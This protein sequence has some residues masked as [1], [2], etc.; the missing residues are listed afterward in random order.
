MKGKR[1]G[2][3]SKHSKEKQLVSPPTRSYWY[4][5]KAII[6]SILVA[7]AAIFVAASGQ[8][9]RHSDDESKLKSKSKPDVSS[10]ITTRTGDDSLRANAQD[11]V[12]IAQE[13]PYSVP[14]AQAAAEAFLVEGD[15]LKSSQWS[16]FALRRQAVLAG[17]TPLQAQAT[18]R[19]RLIH[20]VQQLEAHLVFLSRVILQGGASYVL[21][22]EKKCQMNATTVSDGL[23]TN[24]ATTIRR[25]DVAS[26]VA[27]CMLHQ[28]MLSH[29]EQGAN[30]QLAGWNVWHFLA[31]FGSADLLQEAIN[32]YRKE[33][34]LL[35]STVDPWGRDAARI[36]R[37]R[38]F[39]EAAKLLAA[40]DN[41]DMEREW[42]TASTTTTIISADDAG[43]N[44]G[45]GTKTTAKEDYKCDIAVVEDGT[46]LTY[47]D[48]LN[49]YMALERPVL[50][51]K[52]ASASFYQIQQL[53]AK[54]N[55]HENF[56][57]MPISTGSV[58]YQ[59]TEQMSVHDF[60]IQFARSTRG[61]A[62]YYLF[63]SLPVGHPLRQVVESH[64][65][66]Y[67][68]NGSSRPEERQV[69]LAIGPMDSGAPPHY[70]KAAVNTMFY[71]RKKWYL[72][73]PKD[74]VYT[75]LSSKEWLER[76]GT[77][78]A[79]EC[80]QQAGD[81]LFV[82]DFWGHGTINLMPSVAVASE[83]ITPRMDFDM[84]L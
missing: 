70:H 79:L 71:G 21:P 4:H 67:A 52:G 34:L 31:H 81:V 8:L 44:G 63:E 50:I 66:D 72:F 75:S 74:A 28:N 51:R 59:I 32:V 30:T 10:K 54:K 19:Y 68:H 12:K 7:F 26:L 36:S 41:T 11:A 3:K 78:G 14:K 58:P 56:G 53:L 29:L 76:H 65:P 45:W 57:A 61:D 83:F 73:P 6:V 46:T 62:P 2:K 20:F 13:D 22:L 38:G 15:F 23:R 80:V 1:G 77:E 37:L 27:Q 82:P 42:N 49:K 47:K 5:S 17:A 69:Q 25:E 24:D 18:Q 35:L 33:T 60:L 40:D 9:S 48:F 16:A 39:S 84:V 64:F 55:F 43:D